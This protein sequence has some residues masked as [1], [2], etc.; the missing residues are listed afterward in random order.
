MYIF[1]ESRIDSKRNTGAN[2]LYSDG[3]SPSRPAVITPIES[4]LY[5][6]LVTLLLTYSCMFR[7]RRFRT[8]PVYLSANC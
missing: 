5:I 4:I 3:L 6:R 7:P 8:K 1:I 2:T